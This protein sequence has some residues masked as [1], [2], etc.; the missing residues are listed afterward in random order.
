MLDVDSKERAIELAQRI[1]DVGFEGLALEDAGRAATLERATGNPVVTLNRAVAA[2]M[3]SGP[4]AGPALVDRLAGA[5]LPRDHH[6]L[7]AVRAHL[8]ERAGDPAAARE[9]YRQAARRTL[10]APERDYLLPGRTG[11][12]ARRLGSPREPGRYF[13]PVPA[14]PSPRACACAWRSAA[15]IGQNESAVQQARSQSRHMYWALPTRS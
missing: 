13:S 3:V 8:R 15:P 11:S 10:S 2:A 5:A 14:W 1:P 9:I 7:L 6:R 12:L 4:V